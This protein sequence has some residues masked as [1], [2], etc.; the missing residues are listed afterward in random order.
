MPIYSTYKGPLL[1]LL[2]CYTTGPKCW[3]SPLHETY[4]LSHD[5]PSSPLLL[6][7]VDEKK[8]R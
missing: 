7:Y 2:G 4:V 3:W 8:E 1:Y 5:L 6:P